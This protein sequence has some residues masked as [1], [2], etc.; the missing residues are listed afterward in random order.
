MDK[1]KQIF[2]VNDANGYQWRGSNVTKGGTIDATDA[3]PE[4]AEQLRVDSRG[5]N[6]RL[7]GPTT[8]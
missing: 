1:P 5:P 2:T 7:G 6:A 8:K 3:T 4:E